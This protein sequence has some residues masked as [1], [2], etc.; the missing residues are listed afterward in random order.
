MVTNRSSFRVQTL[1][2]LVVVAGNICLGAVLYNFNDFLHH[3]WKE[4]K[5]LRGIR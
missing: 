3:L 4:F 5:P 1:L 2:D